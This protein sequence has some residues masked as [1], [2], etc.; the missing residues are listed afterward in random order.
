MDNL[1]CMTV[2]E[3]R[4]FY[5]ANKNGTTERRVLASYAKN[6]ADAMQ[7]RESGAVASA[8]RIEA[9]CDWLYSKFPEYLRW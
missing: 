7:L 4:E 8:I 3:L 9:H 6:K 1:D 5:K 2:E